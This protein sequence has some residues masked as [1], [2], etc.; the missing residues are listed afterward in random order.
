MQGKR[1]MNLTMGVDPGA[2]TGIAVWDEDRKQLLA[3][4]TIKSPLAAEM[5]VT[6]A[7]IHCPKEILIEKPRG[8]IYPRRGQ[9]TLQML[10]IARNVGQCQALADE[11]VRALEKAGWHDARTIPPAKGGTKWPAAL[12]KRTFGYKGKSSSH[13]RD[14]AVIARYGH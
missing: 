2:D 12:F 1:Q 8:A 13:S 3:L 6:M 4:V 14:A 9:G 7:N 11:I 5:A 10:K